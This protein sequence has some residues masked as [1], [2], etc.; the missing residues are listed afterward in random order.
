MSIA[1]Q[2]P[3]RAPQIARADPHEASVSPLE[4]F[5]DLVFVFALTQVTAFLA[6]DPTFSQLG[7]GAIMLALIWW[8]WTGYTWLTSTVDPEV[9]LTRLVMFAAMGGMLVI[10]LATPD[11]FGG[12]GVL[13]G[14]GYL[15]V[16]L[17]HAALFSLAARGDPALTRNVLF[18]TASIV[19]GAGFIL[20]GALA[21]E[22]TTRDLMWLAAGAARLRHRHRRLGRGRLEGARRPLRRAL[23]PGHD[24]R[25]RRVDRRDRRGA[26]DV[27]LGPGELVS[28]LLAVALVCALWWT[29]FDVVAVVAEERFREAVG[30]DQL[31][32]ARDAYALLHLPMIIGVVFFALGVKKVLEHTG[33][34]LKAMPATALCG[35]LALYLLAHVAFRLRNVGSVAWH[36]LFTAAVCLALIPVAMEVAGVLS[37]ALLLAVYVTLIAWEV[38]HYREARARVRAARIGR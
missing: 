28:A 29:Y 18:L 16:R 6:D 13:W 20:V 25:L 17:L 7:R 15:A 27:D 23:R 34:P 2:R 22:G 24:H 35:G 1:S 12:D 26:E 30:R 19:P 36:R 32:I 11:A 5:F 31:L 10:A 37:L 33:D 3:R 9:V 14:V 21:F 8:A 38:V 4:L